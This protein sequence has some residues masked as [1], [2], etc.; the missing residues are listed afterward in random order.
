MPIDPNGSKSGK[1]ILE[2]GLTAEGLIGIVVVTGALIGL[3][4]FW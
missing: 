4:V 3:V 2:T 1:G